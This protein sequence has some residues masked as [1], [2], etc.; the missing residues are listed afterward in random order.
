MLPDF[1]DTIGYGHL[2]RLIAI[3]EELI[4]RGHTY[5]FHISD[6]FDQV[7]NQLIESSDLTFHCNC[8]TDADFILIDS[9]NQKIFSNSASVSSNTLRIQI[10]DDQKIP[11]FADGYIEAS[12]IN[13]WLPLNPGAPILRF[14]MSPI[15][16]LVFD[17][18][19]GKKNFHDLSNHKLLVTLGSTSNSF[20]ILKS[21]YNSILNSKYSDYELH[22]A[23]NSNFN[24]NFSVEDL[25]FNL[26]SL[27]N[28]NIVDIAKDFQLIISACGVTSWELLYANLPF[29][30]IG[31]AENQKLQLDYFVKNELIDGLMYS[32]DLTFIKELSERLNFFSRF[33]G[34]KRVKNGRKVVVNWLETFN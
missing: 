6:N 14:N 25:G 29:L 16:R 21:I 19:L 30:V 17:Q 7:A 2:S 32:P 20:E 4:S 5:C 28:G 3:S 33:K 1:G 13:P 11:F 23:A 18:Y 12:P 26:T 10:V 22:Y 9:Y 15:L 8:K 34:N 24:L 27:E 31:T